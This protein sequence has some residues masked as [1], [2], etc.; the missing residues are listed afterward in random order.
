[1][2]SARQEKSQRPNLSMVLEVTVLCWLV[3]ILVTPVSDT[4]ADFSTGFLGLAGPS[5]LHLASVRALSAAQPGT[6]MVPARL[7]LASSH[8]PSV[9]REPAIVGQLVPVLVR[10]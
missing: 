7:G 10:A 8:W 9:I 5:Y 3:K 2:T 4:V 6:V 1:M